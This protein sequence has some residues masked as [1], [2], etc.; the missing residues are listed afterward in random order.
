MAPLSGRYGAIGSE[1]LNAAKP[2]VVTIQAQ[3]PKTSTTRA[4]LDKNGLA[5]R[6]NLTCIPRN[7]FDVLWV[8]RMEKK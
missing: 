8:R 6:Q 2:K 3:P 5:E 7:C 4:G 1:L